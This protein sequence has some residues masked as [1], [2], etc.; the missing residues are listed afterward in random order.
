MFLT[1]TAATTASATAAS[2]PP[3]TLNISANIAAMYLKLFWRQQLSA[4][5]DH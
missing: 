2:A 5:D 3:I 4:Q 1:C